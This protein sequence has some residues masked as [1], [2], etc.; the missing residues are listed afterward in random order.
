MTPARFNALTNVGIILVLLMVGA[1]LGYSFASRSEHKIAQAQQLDRKMHVVGYIE[2][3]LTNYTL[4]T[5]AINNLE[6]NAKSPQEKLQADLFQ[7]NCYNYAT[8]LDI[9]LMS[10]TGYFK[11]DEDMQKKVNYILNRKDNSSIDSDSEALTRQILADLNVQIAK[12]KAE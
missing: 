10:I 11:T 1:A 5:N 9:G 4:C 3:A 12:D 8:D 7:F 6:E 2:A